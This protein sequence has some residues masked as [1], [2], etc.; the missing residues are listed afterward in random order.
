[1]VPSTSCSSRVGCRTR[2]TSSPVALARRA[3]SVATDE[4]FRQWWAT[5]LRM[6]ASPGAALALTRMN[7]EI[8]IRH[9]LSAIRVPTL[10]MHRTDVMAIRVEGSRYADCSFHSVRRSRSDAHGGGVLDCS[11][12]DSDVL[13][14]ER[15]IPVY[16][17]PRMSGAGQHSRPAGKMRR[18]AGSEAEVQA[19]KFVQIIEFKT[20]RIDEFN[21]VLDA[22]IAK[23]AGR[24]PHR[25]VHTKDRDA[26]QP[27]RT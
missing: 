15:Y 23:S 13:H 9:L 26:E 7:F 2:T 18:S 3:P 6:S 14:T 16:I 12:L 10:I 19:M 27:L 21:D 4:R 25:V 8:D 20:S 5:Y 24:T 1:M 22:A 11:A 17:V